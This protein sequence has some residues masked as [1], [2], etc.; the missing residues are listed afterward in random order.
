MCSSD[1]VLLDVARYK[2][3]DRLPPAYVVT[4]EDLQGCADAQKVRT[5]PGDILLVRTGSMQHLLAG[6][7]PAAS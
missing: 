3:L 1:L 4:P 5:R 6:D 2:G 7:R